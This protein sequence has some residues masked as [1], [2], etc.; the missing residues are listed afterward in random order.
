MNPATGT[1]RAVVDELVRGGMTDAVLAPGSRSAALALALAAAERRGEISLH[2]RL[3]ERSAGYLALG[4]AKVQRRPVAVVTTSGTAAVN[5]HPAVVEASYS[6]VPL[7][8]VTADRP[9]ALQGVGANQTIDQ[10]GLYGSEV[11][12]YA[13]VD[14]AHSDHVRSIVA[15]ALAVSR[16]ETH[17]GP[18]HLNVPFAD[19]LVPDA[20]DAGEIPPGRDGGLPW[21]RDRRGRTKADQI[22]QDHVGEAPIARG[23]VVVGDHDIP[24]VDH[25]VANLSNTMGWPVISEPSGHC[26]YLPN[27]LKHGPLLAGDSA[28]LRTHV[29]DIV[30]TVGSVGLHR[31]IARLISDAGLHVAIDPRPL[32]ALSDPSRTASIV[33]SEVPLA[34]G[35]QRDPQ[36]FAAWK[37]AD[38]AMCDVVDA[39]LDSGEFTGPV[40]VKT[41]AACLSL[42]DLLVCGPSWPIRHLASYVGPV[43]ARVIANRGTSG[44]DGVVST[45]WGAALAHGA[46]GATV[47]VLG[48]LT[49]LYDRNGLL[50]G[51]GERLPD[52]TYIVIDNDG[53]GIFSS[54]EQ[55]DSRFAQDFERVFGTPHGVDL[56]RALSAPAVTVSEAHDAGSLSSEIRAAKER[57]GVNIVV[58]H[59]VSRAREAAQVSTIAAEVRR[60]LA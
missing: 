38:E 40:A 20:D 24:K 23:V 49:A 25:L 44:I 47:C 12:W 60:V 39:V 54:L 16:A 3:D 55:G 13:Q 7:I 27:A 5:L 45:A 22:L 52:L 26:E 29:P 17:P 19:P 50:A 37:A 21:V 31:G 41:A 32:S 14:V 51:S 33:L 53:G 9:A 6:G 42:D 30:L 57:G 43:A 56:S 11:R 34:S 36:W 8:A 2:V 59:V 1:A 46:K 4:L 18:V 10:R 28:F 58:A 35:S 48:D 15:R